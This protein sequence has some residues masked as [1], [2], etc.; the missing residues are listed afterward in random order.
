MAVVAFGASA[1]GI[2]ALGQILGALPS[3]FPAALVVAQ[4]LAPRAKSYLPQVLG[5]QTP[6]RV[7]WAQ[8]GEPLQ[9]GT[10]FIAPP[11]HHLLV[12]PDGTL[13]LAQTKRVCFVR[14][15]ADVLF[16]SL[17]ANLGERAIAVVLSG[18]GSNGASGAAAVQRA[19]GTVI[20]Q[21]RASCQLFGM[22][23]AVIEAECVDYVLPVTEIAP[24]LV[25]LVMRM[26]HGCGGAG[27]GHCRLAKNGQSRHGRG[28]Q[29]ALLPRRGG[30]R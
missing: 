27:D 3:N 10:V 19:G 4:H 16:A 25:N 7:K 11:D 6:L 29:S 9:P 28:R 12:N 13:A 5:R 30:S 24:T 8:E 17:A 1:G 18:G 22:P 20:A 14:P 2:A 26:I 21:N 15:A 23:H